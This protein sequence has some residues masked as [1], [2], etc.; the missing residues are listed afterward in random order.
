MGFLD[1]VKAGAEDLAAK[2]R[3]EAKELQTKRELGQAYTELGKT[4]FELADRGELSHAD[5][6]AGVERIRSL[7][8]QLEA[9]EAAQPVGATASTEPPPSDAPPAMPS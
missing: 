4:A 8:A 1:K 3:E 7:K 6:S 9:E 5:L 2:A